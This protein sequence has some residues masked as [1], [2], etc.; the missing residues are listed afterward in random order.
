MAKKE[1]KSNA[2]QRYLTVKEAEKLTGITQ[3]V[4]M[5]YFGGLTTTEAL[6]TAEQFVS[7]SL[8]QRDA[9]GSGIRLH[10]LQ[11]DY[12]RAEHPDRAALDLI[13][14]AVRL[15]A[16]VIEK[17]PGQFAPQVIGWLLAYGDDPAV[18]RFTEETAAG[19]QTCH[20]TPTWNRKFP[21]GILPR[22]AIG[23]PQ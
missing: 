4:E 16:H 8:A 7:L 22:H 14:G 1:L 3:V 15:S 10:D 13:H 17:E 2:D 20:L 23:P 5:R 18:G 11:L 19:T 6:E 9:D 21:S 12:V